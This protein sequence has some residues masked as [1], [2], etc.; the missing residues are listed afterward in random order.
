MR[1]HYRRDGAA[2][3]S[4]DGDDGD[5]VVVEAVVTN[6]TPTRDSLHCTCG[7]ELRRWSCRP[8][9]DAPRSSA[10]VAIAF[11]RQEVVYLLDERD[12][13]KFTFASGT[14]GAQIAVEEA[15]ASIAR[16]RAA[17]DTSASA[18]VCTGNRPKCCN[19]PRF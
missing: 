4:G 12:A 6:F 18:F 5:Q 11:Q 8:V 17:T 10:I 9:A 2:V 13:Q 3:L 15:G 19:A 14:I 1:E 16:D 7:A